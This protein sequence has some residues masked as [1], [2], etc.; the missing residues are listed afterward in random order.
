M[1]SKVNIKASFCFEMG[2]YHLMEDMPC[3]DYIARHIGGEAVVVVLCD[4]AG[5]VV[6]SE[7]AAQSVA[8]HFS[9]EFA[10]NF[11]Y[12][13]CMDEENFRHSLLKEA[14]ACT[15]ESGVKNA[16]TFL[17]C[18]ISYEG[19]LLWCHIGDGCIFGCFYEGPRVISEPENG[20]ELNMTYFVSSADVVEHIHR[21]ELQ[22]DEETMIVMCSDGISDNLWKR[23]ENKF[24]PAFLTFQKWM[25]TYSEQE[26]SDVLGTNLREVFREKTEDDMS[27]AIMQIELAG[28]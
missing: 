20:E 2:N 1:E 12:W 7:L 19:R 5:S 16:C 8:E 28:E 15:N 13:E 21:G 26:V 17:L 4:G 18:A 10:E 11:Y 23:E 22:V 9:K 24:A 14:Q 27:I 25:E 6:H 3:Q